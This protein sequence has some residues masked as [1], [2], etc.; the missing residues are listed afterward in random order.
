VIIDGSIIEPNEAL[1]TVRRSRWLR[2]DVLITYLIHPGTAFYV[3]YTNRFDRLAGSL[4]SDRDQPVLASTASQIFVKLS[5][6][7]RF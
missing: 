4:Y 3:G 6:L 7:L 1:T 5:Y 2:P